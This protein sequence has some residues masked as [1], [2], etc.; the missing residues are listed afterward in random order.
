MRARIYIE[1]H[2]G[3]RVDIGTAE[4]RKHESWW[5]WHRVDFDPNLELPPM[6]RVEP[7]EDA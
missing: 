5:A 2:D 7:M 6:F 1:Q 4:V 3:G